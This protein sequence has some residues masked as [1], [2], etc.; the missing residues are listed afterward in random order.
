MLTEF[1]QDKSSFF[2]TY[3]LVYQTYLYQVFQKPIQEF[4]FFQNEF[5]GDGLPGW[6]II[7][8]IQQ[9][10]ELTG[11]LQFTYID[12]AGLKHFIG[13]EGRILDAQ[14]FRSSTHFRTGE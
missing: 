9:A 2:Q 3:R 7:K 8:S 1:I 14:F 12:L 11:C 6:S 5:T 4:F 13:W 10:G